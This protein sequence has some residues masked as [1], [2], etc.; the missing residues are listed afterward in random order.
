MIR[1]INNNDDVIDSR[2]VIERAEEL[3]SRWTD[4]MNGGD[5]E[6]LDDAERAELN[7]LSALIDEGR[8]SSDDWEYGATLVRDSYFVEYAQQLAEDIGAVSGDVGWP[9]SCIDWERAADELQMDYT[10]VDFDG[11]TYWTR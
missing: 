11:V 2:E 10:S 7:A 3:A 5:S 4:A 1:E 6:P 8:N 9:H